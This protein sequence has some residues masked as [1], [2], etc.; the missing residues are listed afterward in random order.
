MRSLKA[1]FVI[2][3]AFTSLILVTAILTIR[4]EVLLEREG[5]ADVGIVQAL[6][7]GKADELSAFFPA[8]VIFFAPDNTTLTDRTEATHFLKSLFEMHPV[9]SFDTTSLLSGKA[10]NLSYLKGVLHTKDQDFTL[11]ATIYNGKIERLDLT[12]VKS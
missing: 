5:Q 7:S 4:T 10:S 12:S 2:A 11:Y 6:K 8:E 1:I 3:L 9:R